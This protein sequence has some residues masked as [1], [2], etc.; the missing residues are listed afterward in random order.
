MTKR[1][2]VAAVLMGLMLSGCGAS[3]V[4][5]LAARTAG[6]MKAAAADT[7]AANPFT[8]LK[9]TIESKEETPKDAKKDAKPVT[10]LT[11][12]ATNDA[13][14]KVAIALE[15]D[16]LK[17]VSV[18][19]TVMVKDGELVLSKEDE[20]AEAADGQREARRRSSYLKVLTNLAGGLKDT[21]VKK[22]EEKDLK[23][24]VD[25]LKAFIKRERGGA[26]D[27]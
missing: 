8:K 5:P 26:K 3:G 24:V 27:E 18:N 22:A 25:A 10:H 20:E 12:K 15:N 16:A 9:L 1:R 2:I 11:L 7:E 14:L 19:R 13:K 23:A 17:N 21:K 6:A 4:S